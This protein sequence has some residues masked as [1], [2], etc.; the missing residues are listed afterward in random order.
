M[1]CSTNLLLCVGAIALEAAGQ[2]TMTYSWSVSDTGNGDG[3]INVGENAILTLTATMDP[4]ARGFAGSIFEIWGDEEWQAN[5]TI[6]RYDNFLDDLTDDG[7]LEEDNLISG[8]EAFQLP[9]LFNPNFDGSNPIVLYEIE[10]RPDIFRVASIE[11]WTQNHLNN[12]VYIDE[13]GTSVPYEG[14]PGFGSFIIQPAPGTA[15]LLL[16][17]FMLRPRPR[18]R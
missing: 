17:A 12:D 1:K 18:R 4:P 11:F 8:I 15:T 6:V 13:L 9:P 5:G 7:T 10:W 16:G 3:W 2:G 14:V